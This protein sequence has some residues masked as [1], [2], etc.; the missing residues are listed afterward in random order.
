MFSAYS[1][2]RYQTGTE[3][4]HY[5]NLIIVLGGILF[6]QVTW[7]YHSDLPQAFCV[8]FGTST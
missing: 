1:I 5:D 4:C 2:M 6:E 3:T 7:Q 8:I